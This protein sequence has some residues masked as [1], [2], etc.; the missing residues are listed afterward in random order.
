MAENRFCLYLRKMPSY[1]SYGMLPVFF[2]D[3]GPGGRQAMTKAF[4]GLW[5]EGFS[6]SRPQQCWLEARSR[7]RLDMAGY[8]G[9]E[10]NGSRRHLSFR[11]WLSVSAGAYYMTAGAS[12]R[13]RPGVDM[14]SQ[15]RKHSWP[16]HWEASPSDSGPC[17]WIMN[18]LLGPKPFLYQVPPAF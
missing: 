8:Q 11:E 14:H 18:H 10:Q 7:V 13:T 4:P 12:P 6:S 1:F 2:W 17:S 16:S 3:D 9:C 15:E 5:R